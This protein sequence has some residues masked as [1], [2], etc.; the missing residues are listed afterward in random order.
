MI[1]YLPEIAA[2]ALHIESGLSK[3]GCL[4]QITRQS[5]FF[6]MMQDPV[7]KKLM[8]SLARYQLTLKPPAA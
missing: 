8:I 3:E 4:R 5:V 1:I 2:L 7:A 6:S